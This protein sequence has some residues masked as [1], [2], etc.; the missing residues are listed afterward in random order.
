MNLWPP[1]AAV[2]A[3]VLLAGC[4]SAVSGRAVAIGPLPEPPPRPVSELLPDD[5][6]PS[7]VSGFADGKQI[8]GQVR[9][10]RG[11]S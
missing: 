5:A 9:R 4:S 2:C 3:V 1:G 7:A 6:E 11:T 8:W 10:R